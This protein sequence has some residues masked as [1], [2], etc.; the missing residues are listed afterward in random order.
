MDAVRRDRLLAHIHLEGDVHIRQRTGGTAAACLKANGGGAHVSCHIDASVSAGTTACWRN[1]F[2]LTPAVSVHKFVLI[3]AHGQCCGQLINTVPVRVQHLSG[4]WIPVASETSD[5]LKVTSHV[6]TAWIDRFLTHIHLE[7]E[8]EKSC[9]CGI[10]CP[11][12]AKAERHCR[13]IRS[14][15]DVSVALSTCAGW[16]D[17]FPTGPVIPVDELEFV[18]ADRQI[19]R[20]F[21]D[22]VLVGIA[23]N[24]AA[25]IPI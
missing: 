8:V 5:S 21:V 25:W 11:A 7:G 16:V 23:H 4:G 9:S 13:E 3:G 17:P 1:A 14:Y 12:T 10:A 2:V 18:A 22:G 24:A 19:D 20:E 6:H 15:A